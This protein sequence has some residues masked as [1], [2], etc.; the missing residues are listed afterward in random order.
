MHKLLSFL[1]PVV[2][3]HVGV[4]CGRPFTLTPAI[5]SHVPEPC[6]CNRGIGLQ[7]SE[8]RSGR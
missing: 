7:L 8:A 2:M 1:L 5:M 6:S 3:V 4:S